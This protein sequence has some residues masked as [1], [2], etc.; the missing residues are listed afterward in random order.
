M[1]IFNAAFMESGDIHASDISIALNGR[2]AFHAFYFS[3][4]RI[5]AS[6]DA[7][8]PPRVFISSLNSFAV[9]R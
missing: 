7:F 5:I 6:A 3:R 8:A 1:G 9:L 4:K 2:Y